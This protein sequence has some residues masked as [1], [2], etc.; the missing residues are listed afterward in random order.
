LGT[1][2]TS[3]VEVPHGRLFLPALVMSSFASGPIALLASL[4]LVDIG[5][6]FSTSVGVAGQLN[7]VYSVAALA[8][9]LITG[10]LST[11]FRHRSL[12]LVGLVL[13]MVS[14]FGCY[15][16]PDFLTMMASF[17]LSGAG[18]AMVNPMT[19]A[20]VGRHLSVQKRPNAIGGIVAGGALVYV[21]GAPV[22]AILAGIGGWRL[23]LLGFVA[24]VLF[25]GFILSFVGLPSVRAV[26][27]SAPAADTYYRSFK[28]VLTNRSAVACLVGDMLRSASFVAVVFFSASFVRQRFY[29]STDMASL[30]IIGGALSYVIGGLVSGRLVSMLGRKPMV[31]STASL[32]G[33]FTAAY[34]FAPDFYTSVALIMAAGLFF[35]LVASAANSLT[36]EQTPSFRGTMMSIDTAALNLGSA[37]GTVV[38]GLALVL[39]GYEGQGTILGAACILGALAWA[40]FAVDPT[41]ASKVPAT[42]TTGAVV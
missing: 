15:L 40:L 18:Y 39:S 12:L 7:T 10:A 8:M 28:E 30:M 14:S 41:R 19:F 2:A 22:I 5:N 9:A 34:V 20:L 31:V 37:L 32:A 16:A 11:K 27:E 23:P 36:L 33:A 17:S 3:E 6:T 1:A 26:E 42:A 4:L 35:G 21:L 29:V 25:A 13:M 24:P 38:G